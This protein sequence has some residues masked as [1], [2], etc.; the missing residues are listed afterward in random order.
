MHLHVQTGGNYW[1]MVYDGVDQ[2]KPRERVWTTFQHREPDQVPRFECWIEPEVAAELGQQ[3]LVSAYASLGLDCI[4][5]PLRE[6]PHSNAW[7]EGVDE[8]GRVWKD[9]IYVHGLVDNEEDLKRYSPP[10]DLVEEFFDADEVREAMELYPDHCF[11]Y[12]SHV[13]PFTQAFM[14]MGLEAFFFRIHDDPRFVEKLLEARTEWCLALFH[15]AASLAVDFVVL[16]DDAGHKT[17]PMISPQLWRDLILPYHRRIVEETNVPVV[18]HSDGFI[19]PLLPMAVEAGFAGVHALE[20]AAGVDLARVKQ[21]FGHDLI[22][23][24]NVD[25]SI[26]CTSDL[27]AVRREVERC[28]EQGAPGGGY[29][30]S[31]CNSIFEGMQAH[32]VIEMFR[33]AGEIGSYTESKALR[34]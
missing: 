21:E 9:G 24:G 26:L 28:I 15:E 20:P 33:Y 13:G 29:M 10:L 16:G 5:I 1:N 34:V 27:E 8:W 17:G 31:T 30:I 23:M 18:W 25:T 2:M 4:H 32:S 3:D 14:A 22:L 7:K 19:E 11:I 6:R 12:G